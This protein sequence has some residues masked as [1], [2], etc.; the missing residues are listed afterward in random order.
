M[1][2]A[3]PPDPE[4]DNGHRRLAD[5]RVHI[6]CT[7]L[8][9]HALAQQIDVIPKPVAEWRAGSHADASSAHLA[10]HGSNQRLACGT[11][12]LVGTVDLFLA[13]FVGTRLCARKPLGRVTA[14]D[15][16]G[17]RFGLAR[18]GLLNLFGLRL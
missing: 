12:K 5:T 7:P 16:N 4:A 14:F 11:V 2:R 3:I 9:G 13:V 10:N 8:L 6:T 17:V 18:L 1:N 15:G